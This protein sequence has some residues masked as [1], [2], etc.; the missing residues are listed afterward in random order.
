MI[1]GSNGQ[2]RVRVIGTNELNNSWTTCV[3]LVKYSTRAWS[4]WIGNQAQT[5]KYSVH[6]ARESIQ[7]YITVINFI[8]SYVRFYIKIF[9]IYIILY[10]FESNSSRTSRI[11]V[12]LIFSQI[13]WFSNRFEFF[14]IFSQIDWFSNRI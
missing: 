7:A 12:F 14:L 1:L 11:R 5:S 10:I 3:W 6:E 2:L 4:I 8:I 13:D 9:N